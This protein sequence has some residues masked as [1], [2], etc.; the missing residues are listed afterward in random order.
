MYRSGCCQAIT[1]SIRSFFFAECVCATRLYCSFPPVLSHSY[2]HQEGWPLRVS[3]LVFLC[4]LVVTLVWVVFPPQNIVG[5]MT[6]F[7]PNHSEGVVDMDSYKRLTGFWLINEEVTRK[8]TPFTQYTEESMNTDVAHRLLYNS[9]QFW[10]EWHP[11]SL[12]QLG[13]FGVGCFLF[14]LLSPNPMRQQA[15]WLF[16]K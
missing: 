6:Y 3:A 16:F 7:T 14:Y 2:F 12:P 9:F 15:N 8:T 10:S 1:F 11:Q 5:I 13:L 4:L